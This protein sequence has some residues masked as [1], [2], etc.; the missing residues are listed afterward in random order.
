MRAG[1]VFKIKPQRPF[2]SPPIPGQDATP[3]PVRASPD[4]LSSPNLTQADPLLQVQQTTPKPGESQPE[5]A[6]KMGT[7]AK[8]EAGEASDREGTAEREQGGVEEED[9]EDGKAAGEDTAGGGPPP[10]QGGD[11][12]AEES[13]GPKEPA[14]DNNN[15]METPQNCQENF[16]TIP[17]ITEQVGR[18]HLQ[19]KIP[20]RS[21]EQPSL[22]SV[23][24]VEQEEETYC[25]DEIEVVLV[26]SSVPGPASSG[27][28]D[29]DTV[30]IIITMSCD[31]LTAAQLEESVKQRLLEN[32]QV[33]AALLLLSRVTQ[34]LCIQPFH[35]SRLRK[36]QESATSRSPSSPL[37]PPRRRCW[38]GRRETK[39]QRTTPP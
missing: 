25:S 24:Q 29:G 5:S 6:D 28:D 4:E 38:S 20:S 15:S 2:V 34:D 32:T 7:E 18:V 33:R 27:L 30:K 3:A 11:D 17:E 12:E 10:S 19:W 16:I 23:L 1:A 8:A 22:C 31:P 36:M 14:D 21:E 35:T 39:A 26:D 9:G 13:E 37:T